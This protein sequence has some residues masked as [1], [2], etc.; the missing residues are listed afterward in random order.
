MGLRRPSWPRLMLTRSLLAATFAGT[1]MTG[2]A[3]M[4]GSIHQSARGSVYLEEVPDWSFQ[5]AH[6]ISIDPI[7]LADVFR[8]VQIQER[9]STFRTTSDMEPKAVRAFSDDEVEFLAPLLATALSKADPEE[10]VGFRLVQPAAA[11]T[12]GTAGTLYVH[13]S[14]LYLS[15]TQYR[16]NSFGKSG[17]QLPGSNGPTKR[18][19]SFVPETAQRPDSQRPPGAPAQSSL[20]TLVIDYASLAYHPNQKPELSKI[21]AATPETVPAPVPQVSVL[22]KD[23][24]AEAPA[25]DAQEADFLGQKLEELR[26]AK[27]LAS[28]KDVELKILKRDVKSLRQQLAD[29]DAEIHKL[30]S[31]KKPVKPAKRTAS[32]K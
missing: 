8:G 2:C 16:S 24:S 18:V 32:I 20:T 25:K 7:T 15:L 22:N 30:K 14:Y 19:V 29:R 28:K 3:F 4:T 11:G 9:K 23:T 31:K 12:V 6:P 26:A 21:S 27:E 1:V 13:G 10:I 5:A 17:R